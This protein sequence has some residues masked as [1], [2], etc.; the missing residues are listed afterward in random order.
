MRALLTTVDILVRYPA[1]YPL[2]YTTIE[3][4]ALK[5][6]PAQ[7]DEWLGYY[8]TNAD[9]MAPGGLGPTGGTQVS[10][11]QPLVTASFALCCRYYCSNTDCLAGG[12]VGGAQVH[13]FA[14][15][16]LQ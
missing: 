15:S 1:Q 4:A 16:S 11:G 10:L 2:E 9:C 3:S 14:A 5:L 13:G 7:F 12:A 8:C 6:G